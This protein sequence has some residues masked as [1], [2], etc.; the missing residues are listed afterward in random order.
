M[1]FRI[2]DP[3]GKYKE[4][5]LKEY[6]HWV[7]ELSFRQ[8]TLGCFIIFAKRKVERMSKLDNSEL[9]ELRYVMSTIEEALSSVEAFKPDRFNYLQ[10]GNKLHNLHIHGV[11]R[12]KNEREFDGEIWVDRSWGS[13]PVWSS[14]EISTDLIKSLKKEIMQHL[15]TE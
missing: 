4:G 3:E 9:I 14:K 1:D 15:S 13:P 11:P 2:W 8:H 6:N 5:F 12:Y 10:L 7:L